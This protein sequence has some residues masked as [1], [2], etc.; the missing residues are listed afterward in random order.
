MTILILLSASESGKTTIA[1]AIAS[2]G[3]AK[4]DVLHFD[5]IGVPPLHRMIAEHGS[6]EGVAAR[7]DFRMDG[8]ACQSPPPAI[9]ILF[10]G[11]TRFRFAAE[12]AAA[13]DMS[14]YVPILV[15]CDDETRRHRL[16]VDRG[17]P[18]LADQSMMDWAR[19]LR[20][21]ARTGGYDI[22]DT[23]AQALATSVDAVSRHFD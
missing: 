17:Q 5:R 8:Q 21:E 15:D 16:S 4:V 12:A 23:S 7:H 14:N 19:F 22:L 1:E 11:Q 18:E 6:A 3:D 2:R 10:E 9:H 13:A 20:D